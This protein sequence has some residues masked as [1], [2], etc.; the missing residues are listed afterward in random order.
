MLDS[1]RGVVDLVIILSVL[2]IVHEWG[3]FIVAKLC[4]MRVEEFSLF[5]GPRLVRLGKRGDTEYN[6]RSI[7]LGGF[8]RIAGMD[9]DDVSGGRPILDAIRNPQF[10]DPNGLHSM[11]QQLDSDSLAEINADN[12][13]SDVR[14]L[15]RSA[16][17]SD[18]TLTE[19]G[20]AELEMKQASPQ[21]ND[22]E[23]KLM[24]MVLMA[25][26]RAKDPGLYNQKPIY[27]RALTIFAGPFMSLFFGYFLY[28]IMGMTFGLPTD[29]YTNQITVMPDG[30]AR[31]AGMRTGDRIIAINDV[32]TPTGKELSD[33]IHAHPNVPLHLTLDRERKIVSL[34]VTPKAQEITK[35]DEKTDKPV[36]DA[37]GKPV[38][39][40]VGMIGI[41]PVPVLERTG[42]V[43]SVVQGTWRSKEYVF[44]LISVLHSAKGVKENV[45]GPV[46]IY[47]TTTALQR[48][49]V[50]S[51][52]MMAAAFS[53]SLGIMNLLPI[54]VLDGGHLL[55]LAI[56][57]IRRRRLSPREVYRAQIAGLAIIA[58]L[59]VFVMFND[60][61]RTIM[62]HS[63]Q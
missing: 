52:V 27:K 38:K 7:P 25:D 63:F 9:P 62:G 34:T 19:D 44:S 39:E 42:I 24:Q 57:K 32:P 58:A 2:V 10:A 4:G 26:S 60:I 14:V 45:G 41:M 15:L 3:H 49:G 43:E 47:Q 17:G 53:L 16:V 8:V 59:V 21:V 6:I 46:A 12:V 40:T 55:L 23:R 35:Y 22:D 61:S 48:L 56:E 5:F 28:C 50:Q 18:G 54:P 29:N 36:L 1:I 11:I 33:T 31:K 30:S 13:S 51:L 20:R 37:A